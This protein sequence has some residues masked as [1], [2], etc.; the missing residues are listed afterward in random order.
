MLCGFYISRTSWLCN[1]GTQCFIIY[2]Y[3]FLGIYFPQLRSVDLVSTLQKMMSQFLKID[4]V[5]TKKHSH[6][7]F[8]TYLKIAYTYTH[9]NITI[10]LFV[11][12]FKF[13]SSEVGEVVIIKGVPRRLCGSV[14]GTTRGR[15]SGS[16]FAL[17]LHCIASTKLNRLG[18]AWLRCKW[19]ADTD[20]KYHVSNN[21][22]KTWTWTWFFRFTLVNLLTGLGQTLH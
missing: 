22:E 1:E 14:D 9:R 15:N 2:T 12:S 11:I 19:S 6:F 4:L 10:R 8:I 3:Q 7:L 13:L 20:T 17:V 16:S 18:G 5:K 21:E